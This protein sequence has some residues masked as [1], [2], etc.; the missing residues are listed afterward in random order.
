LQGYFEQSLG[1]M[2]PEDKLAKVNA[3]QTEGDRVLMVGDG[4]NDIPVL[5]AADLSVAMGSASQLA[6]VNADAVLLNQNLSSLSEARTVAVRVSQVI[7]QNFAWALGYNIL[8]LPA[9][10]LGYIPPYLAAL[11]MSLSSLVVVLNSLRVNRQ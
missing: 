7:K 10:A 8:A 6:K 3:L 1:E 9:A 4:I 5:A 11:G 2:L